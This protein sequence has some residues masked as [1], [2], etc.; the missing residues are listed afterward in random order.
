MKISQF[1]EEFESWLGAQPAEIALLI[2]TRAALRFFPTIKSSV[3][4]ADRLDDERFFLPLFRALVYSVICSRRQQSR[5]LI[6][7]VGLKAALKV[8]E[9][10]EVDSP[11]PH[12]LEKIFQLYHPDYRQDKL[13]FEILVILESLQ[14]E[15]WT[16][17]SVTNENSE[18][19]QEFGDGVFDDWQKI[20]KSGNQADELYLSKLWK[21]ANPPE[22]I[23][24][25]WEGVRSTLENLHNNWSV[26]LNW[27]EAVLNGD[28][29][30]KS[31]EEV[32]LDVEDEIWDEGP[33][34]VNS[35]LM[36]LE[37]GI[38]DKRDAPSD[39]PR[40]EEN[41]T[42]S[43][44][45][46]KL[47]YLPVLPKET[48]TEDV[49]QQAL[50]SRLKQRLKVLEGERSRLH[51]QHPVLAQTLEDYSSELSK[52]TLSEVDVLATWMTGAGL[53]EQVRSYDS[54]EKT[55]RLIELEPDVEGLLREICRLHAVFIMGFTE[56][57][58]LVRRSSIPLL[59]KDEWQELL[60]NQ[61]VFVKGVLAQSELSERARIILREL[62]NNILLA[63]I[64]VENAAEIAFPIVK[65][66]L[67]ALGKLARSKVLLASALISVGLADGMAGAWLT[68]L[69]ANFGPVVAL[70]A[71][72]PELRDFFDW[73]YSHLQKQESEKEEGG[74]VGWG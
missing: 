46:G 47:D 8:V 72:Q 34:V 50:L 6:S 22:E 14:E 64:K 9:V 43:I 19:F 39:P 4:I 54:K 5:A 41:S 40:L 11:F 29:E 17:F 51:N 65:D 26:W 56:G 13:T 73:F 53:V 44:N 52:K 55:T 59:D 7:E 28:P 48:E 32:V 37:K 36:K 1:R 74:G 33:E 12:I 30:H 18:L 15:I 62:N 68:F 38:R 67:F 57:E 69:Q 58:K 20:S 16:E 42:F 63:G 23:L 31:L 21:Y 3:E 25:S 61:R 45:G 66:I 71:V 49:S 27:Y 35:V 10:S 70:A 24:T 60:D 2:V